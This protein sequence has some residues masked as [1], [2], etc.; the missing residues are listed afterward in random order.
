MSN[1]EATH[2]RPPIEA[3]PD[4]RKALTH[5]LCAMVETIRVRHELDEASE[6]NEAFPDELMAYLPA[7]GPAASLAPIA[8]ALLWLETIEELPKGGE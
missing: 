6:R 5:G 4:L 7:E 8:A 2:V 1:Q 3:V